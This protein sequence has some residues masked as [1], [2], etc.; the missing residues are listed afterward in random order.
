MRDNDMHNHFTYSLRCVIFII[1]VDKFLV[2]WIFLHAVHYEEFFYHGGEEDAD[3]TFL[4][5][6]TYI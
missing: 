2:C 1:R 6:Y 3:A 5:L 4:L